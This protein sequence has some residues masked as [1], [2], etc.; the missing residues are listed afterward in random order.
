MTPHDTA[1]HGRPYLMLALNLIVSAVIMYFVMFSMIDGLPSFY[2][3][4]NMAYMAL[5]M[6]APMALLMLLLMGSMYPDR[7][8]NLWLG[9]GFTL[10]FVV[11]FLAI[12][13]QSGIGDRQFLRSM[14]PHH[15]GAILMC[16]EAN[17]EDAEIRALCTRI[18]ASQSE[19]IAQMEAILARR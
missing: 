1:H 5:T 14:I 2:N 3:N 19:E 11:A 4:L 16:R 9:A 6:V 13:M 10:L 15:S 18:I 17:L 7:R 12:R 8:L